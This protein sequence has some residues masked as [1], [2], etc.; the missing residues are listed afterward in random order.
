MPLLLM[1]ILLLASCASKPERPVVAK[2]TGAKPEKGEI[3][4]S[5]EARQNAGIE[6]VEARWESRATE[7]G[8][9]HV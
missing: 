9:A 4:L 5:A 3:A 7:I 6:V 1:V 2:D 8:R